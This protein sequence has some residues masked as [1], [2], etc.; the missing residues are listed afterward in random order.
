MILHSWVSRRHPV[1]E[2]Y[3]RDVALQVD[4][5]GIEGIIVRESPGKRQVAK[6]LRQYQATWVMDLHSDPERLEPSEYCRRSPYPLVP[7]HYGGKVRDPDATITYLQPRNEVGELLRQFAIEKYSTE[8]ALY[9]T[10]F[11]PLRHHPRFIQL[12][13]LWFRPMDQ[14]IELVKSLAQYLQRRP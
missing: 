4:S 10:A 12:G 9:I 5:L 6:L 8:E 11:Y 14:S 3:A 7:I 2:D 1:R 13:L